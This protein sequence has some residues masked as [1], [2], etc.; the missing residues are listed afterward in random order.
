MTLSWEKN[1]LSES[2]CSTAPESLPE[3]G[4]ASSK[5]QNR[6]KNTFLPL[7]NAEF[8]R[9]PLF[10][11][12]KVSVQPNR[13]PFAALST[14]TPELWREKGG[15]AENKIYFGLK[16]KQGLLFTRAAE[17]W[18]TCRAAPPRSQPWLGWSPAG[19][20]CGSRSCSTPGQSPPGARPCAGSPPCTWPSPGGSRCGCKQTAE[21]TAQFTAVSHQKHVW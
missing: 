14:C 1:T 21:I 6:G 5:A 19:R 15:K 12:T 9:K 16:C 2:H 4:C 13:T 8:R 20:R 11:S 3:W 10:Y 7:R 18:L 17:A